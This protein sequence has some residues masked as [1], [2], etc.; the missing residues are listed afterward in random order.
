MLV[1]IQDMKHNLLF[2]WWQGNHFDDGQ[3]F[4]GTGY[5]LMMWQSDSLANRVLK[6]AIQVK[7]STLLLD[8]SLVGA[9]PTFL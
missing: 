5:Y 4:L 3:P 7:S 8:P 2:S 9:N 1:W 6:S